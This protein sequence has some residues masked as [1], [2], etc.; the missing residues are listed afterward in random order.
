MA[1]MGPAGFTEIGEA[2]LQRGQYAA[3]RLA[4]VAACP[5]RFGPGFF[6]EFVVDFSA[7]GKPLAQIDAELRERGIFGGADLSRAFPELGPCALYCVTETHTQAD[8]DR[9]AD[10]LTEVIREPDERP[11]PEPAAPLPARRAGTSPPS[12][13]WDGPAGAAC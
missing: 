9:L 12:W 3:S 1:A 10:A 6:R 11:D 4:A 7:A 5:V 2:I 13:S 8:I